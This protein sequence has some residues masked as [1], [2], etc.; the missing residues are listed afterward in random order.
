MELYT[1]LTHQEEEWAW[2]LWPHAHLHVIASSWVWH[3]HAKA[4]IVC[5]SNKPPG[6]YWISLLWMLLSSVS[7][8]TLVNSSWAW[9]HLGGWTSTSRVI[10]MVEASTDSEMGVT[11]QLWHSSP[12][13]LP[14]PIMKLRGQLQRDFELWWKA[15]LMW[16]TSS[17]SPEFWQT[18][19]S[20]STKELE[21][22]GMEAAVTC[23]S[24]K[25]SRH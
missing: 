6:G 14:P 13:D 8:W 22:S 16:A 7:S 2:V 9:R 1:Q 17:L 23:G 21:I 18:P 5:Q 25:S 10:D 19:C 3:L 12:A 20:H 11:A 24:N 15:A 4:R